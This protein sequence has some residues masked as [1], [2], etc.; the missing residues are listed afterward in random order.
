[1]SVA[2]GSLVDP[3]SAPAYPVMH[4]Q[5]VCGEQLLPLLSSPSQV[6]SLPLPVSLS[7]S[8][9]DTAYILIK[10]NFFLGVTQAPVP[11]I[12]LLRRGNTPQPFLHNG[13]KRK[14]LAQQQLSLEKPDNQFS[15][16][17]YI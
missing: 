13:G 2:G 11:R 4:A 14:I 17:S 3:S 8:L 9:S 16:T 5:P 12:L 6:T 7:L 1:M 10:F 15:P